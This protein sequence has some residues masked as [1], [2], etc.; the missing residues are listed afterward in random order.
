MSIRVYEKARVDIGKSFLTL[1]PSSQP[2]VCFKTGSLTDWPV[3]L[4]YP[5]VSALTVE[6]QTCST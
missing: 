2:S 1:L 4:R 6:L 3:S 5:H